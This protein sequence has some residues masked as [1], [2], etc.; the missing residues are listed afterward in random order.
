MV[1]AAAIRDERF[2]I[3][4]PRLRAGVNLRLPALRRAKVEVCVTSIE[5]LAR[6]LIADPR[7][8]TGVN[9]RLPA[10]RRAEIE[11]CVTL[12]PATVKPPDIVNTPVADSNMVSVPPVSHWC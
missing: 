12:V 9:L 3:A 5:L 4:G 1:V 8:R 11:V 7:L 2:L 6:C 10:L